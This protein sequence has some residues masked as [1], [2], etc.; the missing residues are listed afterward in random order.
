MRSLILASAVKMSVISYKAACADEADTRSRL[1]AAC[2]NLAEG[3]D[4]GDS[5]VEGVCTGTMISVSTLMTGDQ[6]KPENK[7]CMTDE[8]STVLMEKAVVRYMDD[9]PEELDKGL[10]TLTGKAFLDLWPCPH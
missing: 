2:K 9:H 3:T 8:V 5:Y 6:I 4:S 7:I 10:I 1:F